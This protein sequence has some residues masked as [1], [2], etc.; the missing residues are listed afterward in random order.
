[1]AELRGDFPVIYTVGCAFTDSAVADEW[2]AWMRGVHLRQVLAAG[3]LR[4]TL[5]RID[6]H[7]YETHYRFSNRA[8][9]EKYIAESA[10]KLREDG[11][12]AFPLER[13]L[14]YSRHVAEVIEVV[15]R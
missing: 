9:Y 7:R 4:A 12:Q 11:L 13:G 10:P 2:V 15:E 3:A 8:A 1:M 6:S 14:T 5:M